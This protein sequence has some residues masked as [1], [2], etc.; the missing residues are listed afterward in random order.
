MNKLLLQITL[1][2]WLLLESQ[3]QRELADWLTVMSY[4]AQHS[5]A[6]IRIF[7]SI[8]C[9]QFHFILAI[10]L[11][12][13]SLSPCECDGG[14]CTLQVADESK[15][16]FV[17]VSSNEPKANSFHPQRLCVFIALLNPSALFS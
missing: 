4:Q 9:G 14:V 15:V 2:K 12:Q 1:M 11:Y 5:N 3:T 10:K 17:P 7:S 13:Q 16:A 8:F 6:Q